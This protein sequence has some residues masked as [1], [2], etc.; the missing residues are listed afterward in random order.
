MEPKRVAGAR[1]IVSLA[2]GFLLCAVPVPFP[3]PDE[4][5]ADKPGAEVWTDAPRD[6]LGPVSRQP[7]GGPVQDGPD[8][9]AFRPDGG[10]RPGLR[11]DSSGLHAMPDWPEIVDFRLVLLAPLKFAT[12]YVDGGSAR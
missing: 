9:S 11:P 4:A 2:A 5:Q 1:M 10:R 7:S 12:N 6:R 8:A 3:S